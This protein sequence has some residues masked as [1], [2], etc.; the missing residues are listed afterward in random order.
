MRSMLETDGYKFSMAEAGWP[1]RIETF[2]DSQRKG[3]PC[4]VPLDIKDFVQA[5]LPT[6]FMASDLDW[7]KSKEYELGPGT[8][9]ALSQTLMVKTKALPQGSWFFPGEPVF[10]VTGPSALVSW[11]E[12]L[13][14]RI[15]YRI[16]IAT[17]GL[18]NPEKLQREVAK[19]TCE[20]QRKI[21]RETLDAV[22]VKC[23]DIVVCQEEYFQGVLGRAKQLVHAVGDPERLFEVGM[24]SATC[25]EQHEIA[26]MAC[27]EAGIKKTSNVQL[28]QQLGM[29]P[30]GTMGHEHVQR[31][32]SDELAFRAMRDRRPGR[33]SYLLDTYDTFRSGVP[34]AL[35][36]IAE[37]PDRLDSVRY[38]SGDKLAQYLF[39]VSSAKGKGL[40]VVHIIEDEL[41]D[42]KT[43]LFEKAR[44]TVE[45]QPAH[46]HYGYGG[47]LVCDPSFGSLTRDAVSAAY[48]LS[49]TGPDAVMKF[50]STPG[51]ESIPGSPVVWRVASGHGP[52]GIVAQAEEKCQDG[53]RVATDD[54]GSWQ[55]AMAGQGTGQWSIDF[56]PA[57]KRLVCGLREE[58]DK[59]VAQALMW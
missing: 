21:I 39:V 52:T 37:Q 4:V 3:G 46:Q 18:Q 15:N 17:L 33:S 10:S 24:R 6:A 31:Y 9:A 44:K 26:L 25:A 42:R 30:V 1:L 50:S 20:Y 53:Y 56:S 58:R 22:K 57:T 40:P 47:F 49:Q 51:K 35:R 7:L 38:D 32:G 55:W 45:I 28:A 11:L 41:D 23:P 27:R 59:A 43:V 34:A 14:L 5:H 16:Q 29:T 48:K 2:Y 12:P 36:V 8:R 13:L 19:V 54:P